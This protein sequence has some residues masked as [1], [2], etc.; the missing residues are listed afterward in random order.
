MEVFSRH[1]RRNGRRG[2]VLGWGIESRSSDDNNED[3]VERVMVD[4]LLCF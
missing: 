2:S 1:M 4:G 3:H